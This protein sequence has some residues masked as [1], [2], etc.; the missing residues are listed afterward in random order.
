MENTST[1]D[2]RRTASGRRHS[3][4]RERLLRE[5]ES[6]AEAST[7]ELVDATGLH[8]NT[9]RGHLDRLRADGYIRRE[10]EDGPGRGRPAWRWRAVSPEQLSPYAGLAATLA[11]A[12]EQASSDPFAPA[13]RAGISWGEQLIADRPASDARGT[14][15]NATA[16]NADARALVVEVMREQGFAPEGDGEV[17]RLH[18]CPLLSAAVHNPTV[19]CAVHEGMVEGIARAHGADLE[20]S[21]TPFSDDARAYCICVPR[22]ETG[23]TR[24]APSWRLIWMLP[25]GVALLAGLNAALLLIGLPAPIDGSR[26][27]EVHGMLLT[28][29]FVGTVISLERA[30]A[31]RLWYGYAAPALLGLGGIALV[32]PAVP[33]IAAKAILVAGA[34]VFV[35]VYIPLWRRQ[36]DA[37]LLTQVLGAALALAGTVLWFVQDNMAQVIP[38]IIGFVVL[39]IA[40]ERVELARI[41]MGPRAGIRLLVHG[42]VVTAALTVG[43]VLPDAGAVLLGAALLSL[44]GWLVMHDVARRT[45]NS[46]GVT[47][48][49]AACILGG[50]V[51]L[52]LAGA[53]LLLGQLDAQRQYDAV[54]HAVFL[55][56]TF[57]MIMAHA[58]TI[59]PAVLGIA[60]PYRAAF[61]APAV[62]LH[63]ALV[64]RIWLGDGLGIAFAWQLGGALGVLAL[65]LFVLTALASAIRSNSTKNGTSTKAGIPTRSSIATRVE[66]R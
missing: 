19:V 48:Y 54:I 24:R 12:L 38:W 37:A 21:L 33:L 3:S 58:T 26:L 29:G 57:S 35:L 61:W 11:S 31:L 62:L 15:Q 55:G 52:A 17:V 50:Y 51:W 8:E 36:Y 42:W 64:V 66:L 60:L 5:L 46:T 4:T 10:R 22:H 14:A 25:A 18:T 27:P 41:T 44:T 7:A 28:M 2:P 49:M 43:I 45:I 13:R 39:T 16:Q 56:Y 65:L 9:V 34:A 23:F 20:S 32:V 30:T 1:G 59:L 40:A 53:V 47:R 6:R 63:I